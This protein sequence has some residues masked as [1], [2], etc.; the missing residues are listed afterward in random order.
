M[1]G[2][3]L[4]DMRLTNLQFETLFSLRGLDRP[5]R[6]SYGNQSHSALQRK[7]LIVTR[8][9]SRRDYTIAITPAGE[10]AVVEHM[11]RR[12]KSTLHE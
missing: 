1:I 11:A 3:T 6:C 7:G 9:V 12:T 10:A 8:F 5:V 2:F 4:R